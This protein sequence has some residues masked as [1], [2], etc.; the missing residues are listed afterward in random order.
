MKSQKQLYNECRIRLKIFHSSLSNLH[1]S[2][3]QIN[4]WLCSV[5]GL[6]PFH[7]RAGSLI[8]V[9][10]IKDVW[11]K[12]SFWAGCWDHFFQFSL[13]FFFHLPQ[14]VIPER[15]SG[16]LITRAM[17]FSIRKKENIKL[18]AWKT[19]SGKMKNG[20]NI[21]LVLLFP[22]LFSRGHLST[23]KAVWK[24]RT[25]KLHKTALTLLLGFTP[26]TSVTVWAFWGPKKSPKWSYGSI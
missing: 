8:K 14:S 5:N 23:L 3:P 18:K 9:M 15:L 25:P 4:S 6:L 16:L 26:V 11:S 13:F 1:A 2:Q 22:H 17:G 12:T 10:L 21:E 24:K 20:K 7:V 19:R